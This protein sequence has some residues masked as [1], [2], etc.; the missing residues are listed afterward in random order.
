MLPPPVHPAA[1]SGLDGARS[2]SHEPV[3]AAST[4]APQKDRTQPAV[5][6]R[7]ATRTKPL[8]RR[9]TSIR[10]TR[11]GIRLVPGG[12]CDQAFANQSRLFAFAWRSS[13]REETEPVEGIERSEEP[14]GELINAK[15]ERS[16]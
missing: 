11:S 8:A 6:Q 4:S 1:G 13:I 15:R 5:G 10:V 7:C 2:P 3:P 12:V 14:T 9:A 16:V